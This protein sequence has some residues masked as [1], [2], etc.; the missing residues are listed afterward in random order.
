MPRFALLSCSLIFAACA[1]PQPVA[2]APKPPPPAALPP[3]A[4]TPAS[5]TLRLPTTVHPTHYAADLT[6]HP[7]EPTFTGKI[8]ID[9]ELTEAT[10]VVW[11]NALEL[12]ISQAQ[13]TYAG[14]TLPAHAVRGGE[15]FVGIQAD[16]PF[17]P[18][19]ATLHLVYSGKVSDTETLGLFREKDLDNWY[20]YSQFEATDARRAFPCFD[21][22]SF[23]ATWQLTLHVPEGNLAVSNVPAVKDAPEPNGMHV[24]S[25][26]RTPKLS[27]YLVAF[28]VGPFEVVDGGTAGRL[29]TPVRV[30]VPK[31]HAAEVTEAA[32]TAGPILATLED[33]F[34][35]PYPFGKMDLLV[36]PVTVAFGAMENPGLV[37]YAA[38]VLYGR[39][40]TDT[41]ERRRE[42]ALVIAHEFAHQW[43]G[44]LVTMAWW[45]DVWLNEAFA[46]WMEMKT[47]EKYQPSWPIAEERAQ[48][49]F[50][51]MGSDSLV[52]AR[53]I[54]Q[55]IEGKNDIVNAF[56]PITY[57]K[58]A[59]IIEM[60]E[61]WV[62]EETF[63][64]GVH[65]YV[66]AH[67]QGN[68][69]AKDFV[70]AISHASG[71]DVSGPFF[72][73][74]D[75]AG[76]PLVK[77]SLSCQQGQPPALQLSQ[78][79]YLPLG[80]QSPQ[81][82]TWRLPICV[83]AS[84]QAK[85][86][87]SCE[88]ITTAQQTAPLAELKSC[89]AWI[90]PNVGAHGYY[91]AEL[92]PKLL[93]ALGKDASKSL[94][95]PERMML[96]SNVSS[97]LWNGDLP[98]DQALSWAP[99]F[100]G[101]ANRYVV[102]QDARF[103]SSIRTELVSDDLKPNYARFIEKT[104]GARARKLGLAPK[105][106]ESED[107]RLL[108]PT[109]ATLV[110]D[111]GNDP[112]L[113]KQARAMADEL[114][115][116]NGSVDPELARA[117]LV[118]AARHGDVAMWERLRDAVVKE[119]DVKRRRD[120]I[121]AMG[122]FQQPELARRNVEL[123]LSG[124]VDPREAMMGLFRGRR[125]GNEDRQVLFQAVKDNYDA[126]ATKLPKPALAYLP[127][128]A[129]SFCDQAHRQETDTFFRPRQAK[130][131]GGPRIL[132][133]VLERQQQC[134]SIRTKQQAAVASFLKR[135]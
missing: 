11:L 18:G 62:G 53:R 117:V 63:R 43:F 86:D 64:K 73:F 102:E 121:T 39:A 1:T 10:P 14:Q 108:R 100:A 24:Y 29:N 123:L 124:K 80:S 78:Q 135:Y 69:T 32:H 55:P 107:D 68:A 4:P 112:V 56:D 47:V 76:V 58:G 28:G 96:L 103:A 34:G 106:G 97:L 26:G 79:R 130:L 72:S 12:D 81:L 13:V 129:G 127:G 51:A 116:G 5:P 19:P 52:S 45:D 7:S 33:Y 105:K 67:A 49:H 134:M 15:D 23:K 6:I 61:S 50:V 95:P 109:L 85:D 37:T 20:A 16:A 74:L 122:S 120:L 8:D 113:L 82:E 59:S 131:P 2:K 75:Q 25:F 114:L 41:V 65:D 57:E 88:L 93:A 36:I 128:V 66:A 125:G 44:D 40:E 31:G 38:N 98:A 84:N 70:D 110:A 21:E 35:I 77:M 94:A 17:G 92:D 27:S 126:L 46:S 22:P 104:F 101:D 71:R 48:A 91:I 99:R 111:D 9:V 132:A 89:P 42:A 119:R 90:A 87:R 118:I 60:F 54:R 115:S 3:P 83:R 30:V 133:Q